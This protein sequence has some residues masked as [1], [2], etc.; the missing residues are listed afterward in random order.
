MLPSTS[1]VASSL[2][3]IP[4]EQLNYV[5]SVVVSPN[6]SPSDAYWEKTY[7][8]PDFRSE[9]DAGADGNVHFYPIPKDVDMIPDE[10]VVHESGHSFSKTIWPNDSD[11]NG[12]RDAMK[13]DGRSVSKYA[14]SSKDEDFSES[15]VMYTLSHGTSCEA[16]ARALFPHRYAKL[17]ALLRPKLPAHPSPPQPSKEFLDWLGSLFD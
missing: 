16:T 1:Q 2:G 14:D 5:H 3:A 6:R 10:T 13:A 4:S 11:W 17:D 9:A 12:W 15:L 7:N 8:I